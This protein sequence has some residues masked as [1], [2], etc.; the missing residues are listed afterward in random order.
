VVLKD[1]LDR[2]LIEISEILESPITAV[3]AALHRG[4]L[5]LRSAEVAL[6]SHSPHPGKLELL[7]LYVDL[8]NRRD[9]EGVKNLLKADAQC[10]VVGLWA[11]VGHDA[12]ETTYLRKYASLDIR[13]RMSL[14]QVDGEEVVICLKDDAG[15]W[16][17]RSIVRIEWAGGLVKSIRDYIYIPYLFDD[18][19]IVPTG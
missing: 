6:D 12:I 17:P 16:V 7:G 11:G 8:F 5:K 13:W 18:A 3:K 4:R 14:A 9:W 15:H 1:V 10:E 19:Q 2:S